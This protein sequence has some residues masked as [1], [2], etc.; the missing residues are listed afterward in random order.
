MFMK[1]SLLIFI[2]VCVAQV[3]VAQKDT[4][5]L[6][7]IQIIEEVSASALG[8]DIFMTPNIYLMDFEIGEKGKFLLLK[9]KKNYFISKLGED[10]KI[11]STL[12]LHFKPKKLFRDCLG[13][14]QVMSADSIYQVAEIAVEVVIYEPNSLTF[15]QDYYADCEGET[16]SHLIYK[17]LE[18]SNQTI[19]YNAVSKRTDLQK[20]FYRTEDSVQVVAAQD[21]YEE[22]LADG[23][24]FRSQMGEIN[25]RQLYLSRDKFQR[26]QF[27]NF[28]I[29]KPDYNPVFTVDDE[30]Y[31]FDHYTDSLVCFD[32]ET[33]SV[34]TVIPIFHHKIKGW[35]KQILVDEMRGKFYTLYFI[36]GDLY[37]SEL[38]GEDFSIV[39]SSKVRYNSHPERLIVYD[40]F[41]YYAYKNSV[42]A[43]FRRLFRQRL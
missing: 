7:K 32:G 15:Y 9:G 29:S 43:P 23:Y 14:L 41:L 21:A 35:E 24:D 40:G 34:S 33:M 10:L 36:E 16:E 1:K 6:E 4:T 39:K 25:I 12:L 22:V 5:L 13:N 30:L 42:G 20:S 11:E 17:F 2:L 38:S 31:I 28:V 3:I 37:I 19:T 27:Y 8:Q 26:L 18:N